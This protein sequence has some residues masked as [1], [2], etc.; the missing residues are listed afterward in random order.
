VTITRDHLTVNKYSRPGRPVDRVRAIVLH[1]V[2]NPGTS[3]KANRD[4]WESRKDGAN[5]YGSAHYVID[6]HEIIEAIPSSEVAYHVGATHYKPFAAMIGEHPNHFTIGVELCHPRWDGQPTAKGWDAAV[7]LVGDLLM[8]NTLLP[9]EI[10]THYAIT[11][12]RCPLWFL[13]HPDE[14]DRFRWDVWRY[15]DGER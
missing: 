3:A 14:L 7:G 6:D 8:A 11:G 13:D 1:W 5:G 2:A 12:K 10:T 9:H 4:F 15:M